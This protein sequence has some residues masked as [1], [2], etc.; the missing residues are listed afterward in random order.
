MPA[1]TPEQARAYD[2]ARR[3][4]ERVKL[5]LTEDEAQRLRNAAAGAGMSLNAY[6]LAVVDGRARLVV[7]L[8]DVAKLSTALA[9][10]M[11]APQ[12]VRDLEADLGRF[13]GRLSHLFTLNYT[14]ASE[15]R[16]EIHA[17]LNEVRETMRWMQP[18][19]GA[20][21]AETAEPRAEIVRVLRAVNAALNA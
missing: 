12:A 17:T 16:E 11:S 8:A 9:A 19:I 3:R 7:D 20:L 15:H 21:Q 5:R 13:S 10:L 14:L 18:T 2:S 4:S 1:K 6:M